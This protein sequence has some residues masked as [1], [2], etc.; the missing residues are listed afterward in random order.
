MKS[1]LPRP[2]GQIDAT[3]RVVYIFEYH[4]IIECPGEW[5]SGW[6]A[7]RNA[8]SPAQLFRAERSK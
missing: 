4:S 5:T 6:R 3:G 2:A 8:Y 7:A 1:G